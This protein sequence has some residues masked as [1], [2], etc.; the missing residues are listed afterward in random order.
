MMRVLQWIGGATLCRV[1]WHAWRDTRVNPWG[2]TTEQ[3]C[4]ACGQ[5]RH[6]LF[7]DFRRTRFGDDPAWREGEHPARKLERE[8]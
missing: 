3:S 1:G 6:H 7:D 2:I 4:V 8:A 5:K